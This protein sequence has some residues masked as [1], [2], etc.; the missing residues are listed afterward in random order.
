MRRLLLLFVGTLAM[1]GV[2][3]V[4]AQAD[5]V[6][7][8]V[9]EGNTFVPMAPLRVLD[10]RTG[11]GPLEGYRYLDLS[12]RV[13]AEATAVVLNLTGTEPSAA[14]YV[15]V[16]PADFGYVGDISNLNLIAG[17]TRANLVT[18]A[19]PPTD[20]R[21]ILNNHAGRVH[22]IADLAGYYSPTGA[23]RF[24]PTSPT[25]VLD[26]RANAPV[27]AGK[28]VEVDLSGQVPAS[29]ASVT[30]NLTGT[31][32]TATTF[33]TAHPSGAARPTASN[34]N[35]VAGQTS[36]NLVTVALGT[37]RKITLYNNTGSV[38]LIVDLAGYYAT[39]RGHRFFPMS[40]TR[41]ADT[42]DSGGP[43]A[44]QGT[45]HVDLA[46][47]IPHTA[48]AVVLNLTGVNPTANTFVTAYPAGTPRP[49]A[50]NLN[51]TPQRDTANSAVVALG[52]DARMT[53]YNDAGSTH[54]VVDLAGT[55]TPAV[56]VRRRLGGGR[57][58]LRVRAGLRRH[59][60]GLG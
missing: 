40:P 54:L 11:D 22:L 21:L 16:A 36:P 20:R 15:G 1:F 33:V 6:V 27:G 13:P 5:P 43:V 24:T 52:Q 19:L 37:G 38:H 17:E 55:G 46:S 57:S 42:R 12:G 60:L 29:A 14:T 25:R 35:L 56:A 34:L 9:D 4:V 45:R 44:P 48:A 2:P 58:L 7:Q 41:A 10:T 26:T 49:L 30:F 50:S 53:L 28:S 23:S 18:V 39:D 8:A 32:P 31:E 3:P 51:L 59:G 47:R